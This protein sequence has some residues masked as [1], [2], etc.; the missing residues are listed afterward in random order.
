MRSS[1]AAAQLVQLRETETIGAI[2]DDGIGRR[3]IET[4][5]DDRGAQQNIET[6]LI[7]IEHDLLELP[8][9]HLPVADSDTR[10]RNQ[11]VQFF[12]DRCN[13][14]DPIVNEVHLTAAFDL[15][16]AGFADND[17]VPLADKRLHGEPVGGRCCDQR[18]VAQSTERHVQRS[19]DRRCRQRQHVDLAS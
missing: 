16:Q 14:L 6:P 8:F 12:L 18:H 10:F 15:A 1:D 3:H 2:D 7:E 11:I 13:V 5:L 9:G 17:F 4:A 19:R